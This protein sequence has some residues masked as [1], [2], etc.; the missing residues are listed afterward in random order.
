MGAC[1][2]APFSL[3]SFIVALRLLVNEGC[4]LIIRHERH[5]TQF[6]AV[7]DT[8]QFPISAFLTLV[9]IRAGEP[10]KWIT[11]APFR[12]TIKFRARSFALANNSVCVWH[13]R[14]IG[15]LH[16]QNKDRKKPVFGPYFS[17]GF[18]P[19]F[20][21]NVEKP[22]RLRDL[23]SEVSSTFTFGFCSR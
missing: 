21:R 13:A 9:I 3:C 6:P 8:G 10:K 19:R 12:E 11:A 15:A 5:P 18:L 16:A 1:S 20:S 14:T 17:L 22:K 2:S 23:R 7:P 4:D